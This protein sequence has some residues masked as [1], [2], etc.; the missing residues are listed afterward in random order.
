MG[1]LWLSCYPFSDSI[2]QSEWKSIVAAECAGKKIY[3]FRID[4]LATGLLPF[5]ADHV[6]IC[7]FHRVVHINF[8]T[9]LVWLDV[10]TDGVYGNG[11]QKN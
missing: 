10:S 9:T 3:H 4:F 7:G 6:D 2:Y 11:I 1:Q 5:W 8:W